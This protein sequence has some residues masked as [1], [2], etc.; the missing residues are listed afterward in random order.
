MKFTEEE[1]QKLMM[2]C[3]VKGENWGVTYQGWYVPTDKDKADR[4]AKDCEDV[5]QRFLLNKL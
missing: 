5:Y 3:F 4:A 1:V 2:E